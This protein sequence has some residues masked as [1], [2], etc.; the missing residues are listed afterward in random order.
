M[1]AI[2]T[3]LNIPSRFDPLTFR[4]SSDGKRIIFR[5]RDTQAEQGQPRWA[6]YDVPANGGSTHHLTEP[7]SSPGQGLTLSPDG[8]QIAFSYDR[9]L[10]TIP[11]DG[12][13]PHAID[14]PLQTGATLTFS[15]DGS[16]FADLASGSDGKGLYVFTRD[17]NSVR[18]LVTD[19]GSIRS[20][21][22]SPD[23]SELLFTTNEINGYP[24]AL[25]IVNVETNVV[26]TYEVGQG[27]L[28]SLNAVTAA[29]WSLDGTQIAISGRFR[30]NDPY[31]TNLYL[32]NRKMTQIQRLTPLEVS[33]S[34]VQ[35]RPQ[36]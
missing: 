31:T 11:A 6:I 22:W 26:D 10:Y 25:G 28:E 36:P 30:G 23:S 4:W 14:V 27:V 24:S 9:T 35:W 1:D 8:S 32:L 2:D 20:F 33:D 34:V 7:F 19:M 3:A 18:P 21:K 12:G 15:P 17:S 16:Q 5:A 29:V 13:E